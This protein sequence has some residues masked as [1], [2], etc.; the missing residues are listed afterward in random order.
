MEL[1]QLRYF[2]TVARMEHMTKAA[3][4]LCIAQPA[5]S[6]TIARLEEDVGIPLFDRH[7]G[8]IRL[9]TF[10][11]AILDKVEKA[12]ALLEEGRKEVSELAGLDQGS[13]HLATS[14]LDRLSDAL[15]GISRDSTGSQLSDNSG[16]DGRNDA[17]NRGWRG[18]H[19]LY[20]ASDR[21]F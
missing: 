1:L 9:N 17:F 6:K 4:E 13:I 11:K 7:G 21:S 10:G 3:Q 2:R 19:M 15:A 5:L 18:R 20:S 8:R 16:F 12:L 14:T